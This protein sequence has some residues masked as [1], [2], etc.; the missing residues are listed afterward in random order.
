MKR[1]AIKKEP[2]GLSTFEARWK[3]RSPDY[4]NIEVLENSLFADEN[5]EHEV[6]RPKRLGSGQ[7]RLFYRVLRFKDLAVLHLALTRQFQRTQVDSIAEE[8]ENLLTRLENIME[9]RPHT[10]RFE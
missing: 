6:H 1:S 10:I 3:R 5:S 7:R 2:L 4:A 8:Y 9:E